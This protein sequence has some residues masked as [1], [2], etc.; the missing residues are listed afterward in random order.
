MIKQSTISRLVGVGS[1]TWLLLV[2]GCVG[3]VSRVS[4]DEEPVKTLGASDV[5]LR[6]MA[7]EMAIALIEL[8][9]IKDTEGRVN[10][11]FPTIANRTEFVDFDSATIQSMIRK[12]LIEHSGGKLAFLDREASDLILAERDGK[13]AGQRT[14][15]SREDLPGADYFLVG[16]AFSKSVADGKQMSS[17]HRYS[18][19]LTDAETGVILWE[20]EY[21]FKKYGRPGTIDR[22]R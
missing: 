7:R 18:F 3:T 1:L 21:E 6:A 20:D 16:Q 8:P 22:G 5:D 10:L 17:Y 4:V 19:R 2:A 15:R 12:G 13:R 14:S 9:V 11:G